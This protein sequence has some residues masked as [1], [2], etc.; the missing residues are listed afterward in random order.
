MCPYLIKTRFKEPIGLTVKGKRYHKDNK[1]RPK[2]AIKITPKINL[3]SSLEVI[4]ALAKWKII[5][6]DNKRAK[7]GNDNDKLTEKNKEIKTEIKKSK[8]R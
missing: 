8:D 5:K 2:P 3:K 4:I 7:E 1:E 6:R